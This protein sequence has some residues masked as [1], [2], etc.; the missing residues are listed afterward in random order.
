MAN[1]SLR[2]ALSDPALLGGRLEGESWLGWRSL[3][4]AAMGEALADEERTAFNKLTGR[5]REPLERVDE[6]WVAA[7]RRAGKSVSTAVLAVYLALLWRHGAKLQPGE[8][9]TVLCLAPSQD[10]AA[11]VF[12]YISGIVEST[13]MFAGMVRAKSADAIE[14]DNGVVV[15]IRS[16]NFRRVRGVTAIAVVID[17]AAFLYDADSGSANSDE[18]VLAALR[19]SLLTTGGPLIAISSPYAQRGVLYDTHQRHFGPEGDP[20]ILVASG[21]SW[22]FNTSLSEQRLQRDID[23]DPESAVSEYYGNFR[24]DV[25]AFL[26]RQAVEACVTRGVV[27]RA[28]LNGVAYVAAVDPSGGA[29]DSMTM[30]IAHNEGG[31]VIVDCVVER[32]PPF[33]PES[34]TKEFAETLKAYR[35]STVRGDRYAGEWPRERFQTHGIAYWPA[36]LNRSEA[37]L[38]FL[39]LVS[40]GRVDLVDNQRVVNQFAALERRTGRNGKDSVDHKRGQHEDLANAV[41]L[42]AVL[43]STWKPELKF[44]PPI[45]VTKSEAPESPYAMLSGDLA[46]YDRDKRQH[47]FSKRYVI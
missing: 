12:S 18:Q 20:S 16:S 17:E 1:V 13:P 14:F 27:A 40:S 8:R 36:D 45:I 33:S 2:Q 29:S 42:A 3:L 7:G 30:A 28:P 4:L 38:A 26:S 43:A 41:A 35:I 19:P 32:R 44:A 10:Q 39:P 37:Y 21:A 9:P 34:V 15:Q 23:R 24:S 6:A 46:S 47:G 22:D 31:R 11:I 25:S 5:E